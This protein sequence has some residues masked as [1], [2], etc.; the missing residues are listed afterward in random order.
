[1][2]LSFFGLLHAYSN[3]KYIHS[4]Y[5]DVWIHTIVILII[6]QQLTIHVQQPQICYMAVMLRACYD[7]S[8][9][10]M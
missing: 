4:M 1:M 6:L 2:F 10:T 3:H 9:L 8:H 5:S 7:S